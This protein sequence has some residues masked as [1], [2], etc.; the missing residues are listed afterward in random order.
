MR[1]YTLIILFVLL[2]VMVAACTDDP[3]SDTRGCVA[4]AGQDEIYDRDDG[5]LHGNIL[6]AEAEE[7]HEEEADEDHEA[8][9]SEE[10]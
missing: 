6:H 4:E 1:R 10:E 7:G 8:E 5:C 3:P 2:A 9:E